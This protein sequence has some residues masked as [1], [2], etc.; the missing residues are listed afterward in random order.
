MPYIKKWMALTEFLISH[1][2]TIHSIV[3]DAIYFISYTLY[4]ETYDRTVLYKGD[5]K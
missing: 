1:I 3:Y 2:N 5:W 4:S